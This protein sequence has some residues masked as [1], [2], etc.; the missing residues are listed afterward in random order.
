MEAV[1]FEEEVL[2]GRMLRNSMCALGNV[3]GSDAIFIVSEAIDRKNNVGRNVAIGPC[4]FS[5]HVRQNVTNEIS[6][7]N[8]ARVLVYGIPALMFRVPSFII[9]V[10]L[11]C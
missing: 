3:E 11:Q 10:V 4:R 8:R 1:D 2:G 6:S 5:E 9:G 7:L